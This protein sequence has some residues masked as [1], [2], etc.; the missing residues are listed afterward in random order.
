MNP[1]GPSRYFDL[2][3]ALDADGLIRVGGEL[4]PEWLLD[5]YTHGIFPWPLV[6][7]YEL[8]AWWSPD[9]RAIIEIDAIHVPRR[10]ARRCRSGEFALTC[11]RDF[12][13]V[14]HRCATAQDRAGNTWLTQAM[15]D[16]YIA[17]HEVG[18]AHSVEAWHEGELVGGIYGVA[19]GG[20]FAAESKFYLRRDA[21]KVA[22]VQ[23]MRHLAARG[24]ALFDIQQFTPH[25][26]RLGA[27]TI[28]RQEFL[29]RLDAA[30]A[31]PV[32]FGE[33]LEGQA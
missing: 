4:S 19:W 10:L 27:R 21:S 28:R 30:L 33:T 26:G 23:L 25:S 2:P 17:L 32:T 22:L 15:I 16:A 31:L 11:N 12:P 8:L 24:F 14:I 20:M 3:N 18:N 1:L 9:P 29:R 13:Q 5:A 6:E 7:E